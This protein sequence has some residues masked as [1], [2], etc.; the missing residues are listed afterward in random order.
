MGLRVSGGA[1]HE[2]LA[3]FYEAAPSL[4]FGTYQGLRLGTCCVQV[5]IFSHSQHTHVYIGSFRIRVLFCAGL[6]REQ[7][8]VTSATRS[9]CDICSLHRY[10]SDGTSCEP[11]RARHSFMAMAILECMSA[12]R[13]SVLLFNGDRERSVCLYP[14]VVGIPCSEEVNVVY[15]SEHDSIVPTK[16]QLGAFPHRLLAAQGPC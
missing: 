14:T 9:H 5:E 4:V 13:V 16:I 7:P 2:E 10:V 6:P 12:L 8:L 1:E 15:L 3:R 11:T